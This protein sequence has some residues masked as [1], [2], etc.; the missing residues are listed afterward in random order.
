M[1]S[2]GNVGP[3]RQYVLN[4]PWDIST[5]TLVSSGNLAGAGGIYNSKIVGIQNGLK[6]YANQGPRDNYR[7]A[8]ALN[9]SADFR[10]ANG[11]SVFTGLV[12]SIS[13]DP[14]GVHYYV[15]LSG[16]IYQYALTTPWDIGLTGNYV[17][18][19][20]FNPSAQ[21]AAMKVQFKEDGTKMF[22]LSQT[23]DAVYEYNLSTAW[24]ISTLSYTSVSFSVSTQENN[25]YGMYIGDSG[26]VMYILGATNR[27]VYQYSLSTPWDLSTASYTGTSF[28]VNAQETVPLAV[29]FGNSGSSM[30]IAGHTA[31]RIFEYSLS[32]PWDVSTATYTGKFVAGLRTNPY[33][34]WVSTDGLIF[35]MPG[36]VNVVNDIIYQYNLTSSST[37]Y[38]SPYS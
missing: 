32:T 38:V 37:P 3:Y 29:V 13:T 2:F 19:R 24:D 20:N 30:Y 23:N 22:M 17:S 6:V 5:V 16:V 31:D 8:W 33:A 26:S 36:S 10:T 35:Y 15:V 28:S 18:V 14:T 12:R 1:N 21:S 27:T 11:Y 34:L 9:S 25:P 4:T 7:Q